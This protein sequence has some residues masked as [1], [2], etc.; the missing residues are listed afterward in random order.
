MIASMVWNM[1]RVDVN[2]TSFLEVLISMPCSFDSRSDLLILIFIATASSLNIFYD[3]ILQGL[4]PG[5]PKTLSLTQ[6]PWL[7][8]PR[9]WICPQ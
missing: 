1:N 7:N 5:I 3:Y 4:V 8:S 2:S 6:T 9:L